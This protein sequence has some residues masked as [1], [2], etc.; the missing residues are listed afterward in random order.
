MEDFK[1]VIGIVGIILILI[2]IY[3]HSLAKRIEGA[4]IGFPGVLISL[5][6]RVYA[7]GPK[8][9]CIVQLLCY[10]G[11]FVLYSLANVIDYEKAVIIAMIFFIPVYLVG[12]VLILGP[13]IALILKI[14][15]YIT[16]NHALAGIGLVFNIIGFL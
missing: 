10:V 6:K 5:W 9:G 7:G 4:I 15:N 1:L 16:R 8:L 2:E 13:L 12:Y 14:F 11:M 3:S